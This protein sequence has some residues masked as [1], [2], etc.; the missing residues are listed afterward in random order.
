MDEL[1][2]RACV[3]QQSNRPPGADPVLGARIVGGSYDTVGTFHRSLA[4]TG[5]SLSTDSILPQADVR[6]SSVFRSNRIRSFT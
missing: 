2:D 5:A 4:R 3:G 1:N 6:K